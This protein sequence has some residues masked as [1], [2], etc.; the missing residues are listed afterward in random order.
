MKENKKCSTLK[1]T[2]DRREYLR[3]ITYTDPWDDRDRWVVNKVKRGRVGYWKRKGLYPYQIR[4]YRTWK[5]NRK[6]QY[7]C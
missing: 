3:I 6:T 7:K 5:H 1:T 4:T 2:T